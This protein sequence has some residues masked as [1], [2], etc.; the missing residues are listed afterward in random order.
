M[1]EVSQDIFSSLLVITELQQKQIDD[2][3]TQIQE[4][5]RK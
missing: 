2:L 4:L 3:Q 1:R 5:T